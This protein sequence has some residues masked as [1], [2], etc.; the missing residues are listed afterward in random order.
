[1]VLKDDKMERSGVYWQLGG[2][3]KNIW[4]L[5]NKHDEEDR[6]M[7]HGQPGFFWLG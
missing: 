3:S 6:W 5:Y 1:M 4:W 2:P 7:S